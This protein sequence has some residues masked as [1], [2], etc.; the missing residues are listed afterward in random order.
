MSDEKQEL[1]KNILPDHVPAIK[2]LFDKLTEMIMSSMSTK[3][4]AVNMIA[5]I[6]RWTAIMIATILVYL[7]KDPR[8]IQIVFDKYMDA[9]SADVGRHVTIIRGMANAAN[10]EEE[11]RIIV[12]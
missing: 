12:P 8:K 2:V 4:D 7:E 1:P 9:F 3:N 11:K 6:L 10:G 5:L